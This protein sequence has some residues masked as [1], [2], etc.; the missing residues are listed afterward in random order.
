MLVHEHFSD[1]SLGKIGHRCLF[2]PY[3]DGWGGTN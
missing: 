1:I 3:F 2:L